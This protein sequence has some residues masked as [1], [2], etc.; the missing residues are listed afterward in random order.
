[1]GLWNSLFGGRSPDAVP[2]AS[3]TPARQ[4]AVLLA[5][6]GSYSLNVV[7]ESNYQDALANI[8]GGKTVD[9]HM[10]YVSAVLVP[11]PDNA[12]DANAVMVAIGGDLVGYLDRP[13]A[14][15]CCD[16][17][18]AKGYAGAGCNALIS[19]GWD[20]GGDRVGSFGVKLDVRYPFE[21]LT[22]S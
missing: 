13:T 9:G 21:I 12:F 20:R 4:R 15:M 3:P 8:V 22:S 1:M 11:Q 14:K 16:E 7:G 2:A 5:G 10:E 17:I 6:D 19:G 18:F